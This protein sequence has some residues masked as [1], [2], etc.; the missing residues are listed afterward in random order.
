MLYIV[1]IIIYNFTVKT[2]AAK[3]IYT[4]CRNC[5][6][7]VLHVVNKNYG[8]TFSSINNIVY[9]YK[10]TKRKK[11][12]INFEN[13]HTKMLLTLHNVLLINMTIRK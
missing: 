6:G 7:T 12:R 1:S 4:K 13:E 3:L 5:V 11:N 8:I 10:S 2:L 9:N